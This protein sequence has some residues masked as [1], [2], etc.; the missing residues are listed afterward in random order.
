MGSLPRKEADLPDAES[1]FLQVRR[2]GLCAGFNKAAGTG[3]LILCDIYS[4]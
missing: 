2:Y 4:I 3:S 1:A